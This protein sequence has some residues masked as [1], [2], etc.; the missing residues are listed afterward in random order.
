[1]KYEDSLYVARHESKSYDDKGYPIAPLSEWF[2]F[3]KC[4]LSFNGP[5]QEVHLADGK[6]YRYSYYVIA[7]LTKDK[8]SLIPKEGERVLVR[9]ADDTVVYSLEVSGFVTY[10]RRYVKIWGATLH[11]LTTEQMEGVVFNES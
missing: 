11:A 6:E 5:A 4:F 7:P 2:A 3:G 8:Y 1:M 9:K 10:K